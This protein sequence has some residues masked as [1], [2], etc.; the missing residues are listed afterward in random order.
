MRESLPYTT[1]APLP[2]SQEHKAPSESQAH[3]M[4]ALSAEGARALLL[5]HVFAAAVEEVRQFLV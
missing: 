5:S 1:E 2:D 4:E 3:A